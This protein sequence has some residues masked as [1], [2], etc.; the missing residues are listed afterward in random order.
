MAKSLKE[1]YGLREMAVNVPDKHAAGL[2]RAIKAAVNS[3]ILPPEAN[4]WVKEVPAEP[5]KAPAS[6]KKP[7]AGY[8]PKVATRSSKAEPKPVDADLDDDWFQ[9][10]PKAKK[11]K[12][13][14]PPE[15]AGDDE[16]PSFPDSQAF[17][18]ANA[19]KLTKGVEPDDGDAGPAP[20]NAAAYAYGSSWDDVPDWIR[21]TEKMPAPGDSP[22]GGSWKLPRTQPDDDVGDVPGK[23]PKAKK[24]R[25]GA[26]SAVGAPWSAKD[27]KGSPDEPKKPGMLSRIFGR[28]K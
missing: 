2:K 15:D 7:D 22:I 27:V 4:D 11:G 3:A 13:T 26:P 12:A 16:F 8:D 23:M 17:Q 28:K 10:E 9:D 14:P 6:G 1:M 25:G 24:Q 5:K 20:F 18:S 21:D 19:P